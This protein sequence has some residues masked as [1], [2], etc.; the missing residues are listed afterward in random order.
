MTIK[1]EAHGHRLVARL[2]EGDVETEVAGW[3]PSAA[4]HLQSALDDA[5]IT[6]YGE[7]FWP[8]PTGHYWWMFKRVDRTLEVA[9]L[10][11]RSSAVG[12]QGVFRAT[13]EV[14][15]VRGMVRDQLAQCNR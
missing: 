5:E 6:G 10:W 11:S 12:W 3:G 15:Y 9:V 4:A 8:E 13:D 1:I 2:K 14:S 7:C